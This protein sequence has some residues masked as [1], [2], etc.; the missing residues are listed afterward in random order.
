LKSAA[1]DAGLEVRM[2]KERVELIPN[3]SFDAEKLYEIKR[4]DV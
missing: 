2:T 1:R 3:A 4:G